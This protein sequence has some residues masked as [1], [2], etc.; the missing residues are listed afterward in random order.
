MRDKLITIFGGGG[1]IGKYVAENLLSLGARLRIAERN[2]D[3]AKQIKTMGR[4]G[5]TQFAHADIR[6][7]DSVRR[8]V[9]GADMVIN[10]VGI[11]DGDF[12]AF[13]VDGARN[14]AT[15]ANEAGCEAFVQMSAIGADAHS[16]SRYGRSKGEGEA[17]VSEAFPGAII[18]RPS[19]VFGAEDQFINRFA[20]LIASLPIVPIIGGKTRFQPV[21]VNDV[22]RAVATVLVAPDKYAGMT[23]EL[24]GPEILTMRELNERIAEACERSPLFVNVSDTAAGLL[25]NMTGWLP[26]APIT[27]DQWLMLQSDNVVSEN[28]RSFKMLGIATTGM[29]PMMREWLVRYRT[30]GR[31]GVKRQAR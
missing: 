18:M 26:G 4:L 16:D 10:L 27:R 6:N 28:A 20:G 29:R 12:T 25:A 23:F 13:H 24:G 8:A 15:A 30:H 7:M 5:Q 22:A 9:H 3:N 19:I 17:A 1:F 21:Y 14:V 11:L 2:P 31:F